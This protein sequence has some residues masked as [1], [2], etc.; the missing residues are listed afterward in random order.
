MNKYMPSQRESPA[1]Y[2]GKTVLIR[3]HNIKNN[4]L[5]TMKMF[6][7]FFAAVAKRRQRYHQDQL[8]V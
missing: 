1:S 7:Y 8:L 5:L 4:P 2:Q 6:N 3:S